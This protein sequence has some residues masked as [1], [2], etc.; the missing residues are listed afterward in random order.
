MSTSKYQ[1]TPKGID[2]FLKRAATSLNSSES[3]R[4][5]R[6]TRATRSLRKFSIKEMCEFFGLERSALN[7]LL[8]REKA[9]RGEQVGREVHYSADDMMKLRLLDCVARKR[10]YGSQTIFWRKKGDFLPVIVCGSQK[11]G[12]GKSITACNLGLWAQLA[13]GLRVGI[14]DADP[15]ATASLYFADDK[16][17]V[18]SLD[19]Q[20]FTNFMGMQEPGEPIVVHDP[21]TLNSFWKETPWPGIRLLPGGP[22]I[23]EGDIN[24]FFLHK[25]PDPNVPK[26]YDL[27]RSAIQRW[28]EAHPP[29]MREQG[30]DGGSARRRGQPRRR[31]VPPGDDR[32][33]RSYHHR[34][35]TS[36]VDHHAEH[37]RCRNIDYCAFAAQ[38]L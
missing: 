6:D 4:N 27:L 14:V 22:S 35:C 10:N 30:N 17:D 34:L 9:P 37:D 21:E 13:Y 19:T 29:T 1:T 38:R 16:V 5:L 3:N 8:Q 28:D 15:Q 36:A 33:P 23:Q 2:A 12:S 18:G 24:L 11:G 7:H 25:N 31:E 32:D 20:T 26:L